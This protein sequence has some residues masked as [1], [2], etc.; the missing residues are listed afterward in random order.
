[1]MRALARDP[2]RRFGRAAELRAALLAI[3]PPV[4]RVPSRAR[5]VR[6]RPP[7]LA[8][9]L[10]VFALVAAFIHRVVGAISRLGNVRVALPVFTLPAL[11]SLPV[12]RVRLPSSAPFTAAVGELVASVANDARTFA[13]V[14][15]GRLGDLRAA[16]LAIR[17]PR[18]RAPRVR[19][20]SM[21]PLTTALALLGT[22]IA[23]KAR[24]IQRGA[25][26]VAS[27][28]A[29]PAVTTRLRVASSRRRSPALLVALLALLVAFVG[30]SLTLAGARPAAAPVA[31]TT[32]APAAT[33]AVLASTSSPAVTAAPTASPEPTAE[34]TPEPTT[35]PAIAPAPAPVAT[36]GGDPA[37]T[38]VTFYR[39]VSGHDYISASG[40]WSDRMRASYPPQT[41]I[42]GRFDATSS[43][44]ARSA[45]LTSANPGSAAVAVDL[46][47]TRT[48]GSVRH[49]VG[50]W[51]LVR[52]GSGWLLD[53]PGLRP[54]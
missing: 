12:V 45:S 41:N 17:L 47:E 13:R 53:Q 30:G 48:D 51:Y 34:P 40:L 14:V 37:G 39:L 26:L 38:I 2:A 19:P 46:I 4:P 44:V 8:P 28:P 11:P 35:A 7:S 32:A 21:A 23:D 10:A 3:T 5:V 52:S 25:A 16:L 9:V 43:I 49:W 6:L 31:V 29:V 50:T 22:S 27:R 33:A 24:E 1:V 36:V 42:W 15:G 18:P 20:P 54:A